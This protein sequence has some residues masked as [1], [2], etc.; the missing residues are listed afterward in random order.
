VYCFDLKVEL[1]VAQGEV[2]S[3]VEK[4]RGLE[5]GL[6]QVSTERDARKAEAER[7]AAAT[8]SLHVELAK[9]KIE[10]HLKEGVMAQ[11]VQS[12]EAAYAET[13]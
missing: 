6:A 8:Q 13:L 7:E 5:D 4:M 2:T 1:A 11:A 9:M 10:L 12:A 3:L